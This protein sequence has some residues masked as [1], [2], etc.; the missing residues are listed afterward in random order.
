MC[1][2]MYVP[3]LDANQ[4]SLSWWAQWPRNYHSICI[5]R[6]RR[7]NDTASKVQPLVRY[8]N[9]RNLPIIGYDADAHNT[10]WSSTKNNTKGEFLLEYLLASRKIEW[11]HNT[12]IC[13]NMLRSPGRD[14]CHSCGQKN[15]TYLR[16]TYES[17]LFDHRIIELS[18]EGDTASLYLTRNPRKTDWSLYKSYL[19]NI[20][21]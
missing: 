12:N 20:L 16:V 14:N 15:I 17:S 7:S 2:R 9:N 19:E 11:G 10:I 13:H 5:L 1:L 4:G 6:R 18:I 8:C 3:R 21:E